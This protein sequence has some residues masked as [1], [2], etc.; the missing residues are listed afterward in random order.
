MSVFSH[1]VSKLYTICI[2]WFPYS[3]RNGSKK[4]LNWFSIG[5]TDWGTGSA[6]FS[7]FC[8][9]GSSDFS[10]IETRDLCESNPFAPYKCRAMFRV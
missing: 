6:S 8:K 5:S 9:G 1:S 4:I 2:F 7:G 3:V 10:L